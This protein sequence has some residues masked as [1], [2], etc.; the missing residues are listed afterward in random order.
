ML[1][2][3][4]GGEGVALAH[5]YDASV[6]GDTSIPLADWKRLAEKISTIP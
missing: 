4:G 5:T 1:T 3:G 2:T 6:P